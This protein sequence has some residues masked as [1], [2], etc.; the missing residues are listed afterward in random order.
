[1][2][3]VHTFYFPDSSS[4][5]E[6]RFLFDTLDGPTT[7]GQKEPKIELPGE[8][9]DSS[10]LETDDLDVEVGEQTGEKVT[11][12]AEVDSEALEAVAEKKR[13]EEEKAALEREAAKIKAEEEAIQREEAE[14]AQKEA[15]LKAQERRGSA[16]SYTPESI[17]TYLDGRTLVSQLSKDGTGKVEEAYIE[18]KDSDWKNARILDPANALEGLEPGNYTLVKVIDDNGGRETVDVTV[19]EKGQVNEIATKQFEKT[20]DGQWQEK[21]SK[22]E[23]EEMKKTDKKSGGLI[24]RAE[25]L[26]EEE[27]KLDENIAK[28]EAEQKAVKK[29]EA[30]KGGDLDIAPG[31]TPEES[32]EEENKEIT[33]V[34]GE[35]RV[36]ALLSKLNTLNKRDLKEMSDEIRAKVKEAQKQNPDI[37]DYNAKAWVGQTFGEDIAEEVYKDTAP[38]QEPE[39]SIIQKTKELKKKEEEVDKMFAQ[40]KEETKKKSPKSVVVE[41]QESE[42]VL[43]ELTT[44]YID[45]LTK[46]S[47]MNAATEKT[48]NLSLAFKNATPE[49]REA[50]RDDLQKHIDTI[51]KRGLSS[52]QLDS[53]LN[54][55]GVKISPALA[56]RNGKVYTAKEAKTIEEQSTFVK[57]TEA[58]P[59][60]AQ[61]VAL[62]ST[63]EGPLTVEKPSQAEEVG[64]TPKQ[65]AEIQLS[66]Y[67]EK[68]TSTAKAV[69]DGALKGTWNV[70]GIKKAL[71]GYAQYLDPE[72]VE[73][74][75][76]KTGAKEALDAVGPDLAQVAVT[77]ILPTSEAK[78]KK[79]QPKEEEK[80]KEEGK[81]KEVGKPKEEEQPTPSIEQLLKPAEAAR[82]AFVNAWNEKS[83]AAPEAK[84]LLEKSYSAVKKALEKVLGEKG[85]KTMDQQQLE[86]WLNAS[87]SALEG[88]PN[89]KI[90]YNTQTGEV[91]I[92]LPR[93]ERAS[94]ALPKALTD[95]TPLREALVTALKN[96]GAE[97]YGD[98]LKA[99]QDALK[100]LGDKAKEGQKKQFVEEINT[101][102][103]GYKVTYENAV[104]KVEAKEAKEQLTGWQK[105]MQLL[106]A[107]LKLL[108]EEKG[109]EYK[110]GKF[111]ATREKTTVTTQSL[112]RPSSP[113]S[114]SEFMNFYRGQLVRLNS[115]EQRLQGSLSALK[116]KIG[117]LDKTDQNY[118]TTVQTLKKQMQQTEQQLLQVRREK[119]V[120]EYVLHEA[121]QFGGQVRSDRELLTGLLRKSLADFGASDVDVQ[122]TDGGFSMCVPLN[123]PSQDTVRSKAFTDYLKELERRSPVLRYSYTNGPEGTVIDFD[124]YNKDV[125]F[126]HKDLEYNRSTGRLERSATTVGGPASVQR[127]ERPVSQVADQFAAVDTTKI[128]TGDEEGASA[129]PKEKKTRKHF[130][131]LWRPKKD[132]EN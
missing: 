109:L 41:S 78:P 36:I 73:S 75:V 35:E 62:F 55:K 30:D 122:S 63:P 80:P 15:E 48:K 42:D 34:F 96:V 76:Q 29:A 68:L 66:T 8:D 131:Q 17:E 90:T 112:A 117:K 79:E 119:K 82:D 19:D 92:G 121:K 100:G 116:E 21:A 53:Y 81:P 52:R 49:Q 37:S 130:W 70:D 57:A 56:V 6:R 126:R 14:L 85:A 88:L 47:R 28:I 5:K 26:A 91:D 132:K 31:M 115:E 125:T 72:Q 9:T 45:P 77:S 86:T 118:Q 127:M 59:E 12:L 27:Q 3:H 74:I 110:D 94:E 16:P 20:K 106:E 103:L 38:E 95:L 87:G 83:K 10:S 104:I 64:G 46:S 113:E 18:R 99:L 98:E 40:L 32:L 54:T 4:N 51:A 33:G 25:K 22:A 44:A 23:V 108:L 102:D 93:I 2:E 107:I 61:E 50:A 11:L 24:E 124:A 13:A 67:L 129:Q 1:M 71:A 7:P 58:N 120:T 111:V 101:A 65:V 39:K 128:S 89:R 123:S 69:K 97:G 114:G 60:I 84:D 43:R 105:I